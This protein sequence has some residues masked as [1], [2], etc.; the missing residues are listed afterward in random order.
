MASAAPA[1]VEPLPARLLS[2]GRDD[3][4]CGD[5][6]CGCDREIDVEDRP[7]VAELGQDTADEH[8]DR[9]AGTSDCA[10][11]GKRLRP[12]V[13]LEGGHDDRERCRGEHRGA[14]AL[15][16]PSCEQGTGR[17]GHGRGERGCGEDA[18]AGQEHPASPEQISRAAAEEQQAPED[19]RVAR[20]RP[21]DRAAADV[22][23]AREAGQRD[24]HGGD[25]E[26]DHQL[27]YQQ[28]RQ[29]HELG[30]GGTLGLRG[31]AVAEWSLG[32]LRASCPLF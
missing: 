25:V 17:A 11:G 31:V 13:A 29:E 16:R 28:H 5:R 7:P 14:E 21:A 27:R 19:E 32:V 4:Q 3:L 10:P 26:D 6:E 9:G 22:E 23:V 1:E 18:E 15:A 20:D 8:T 24:V 30:A 2:V 12:L